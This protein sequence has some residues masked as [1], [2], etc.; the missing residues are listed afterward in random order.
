M[1]SGPMSKSTLPRLFAAAALSGALAACATATPA[2]AA[3][4]ADRPSGAVRRRRLGLR[5]LS[6]RRG[7]AG[8]RR[9]GALRRSICSRPPAA[10]PTLWSSRR[11][12]SPPPSWPAMWTRR[13]PCRRRPAGPTIRATPWA[14]SPVRSWKWLIITTR[15]PTRS[16]RRPWAST[17]RRRRCCG[18]WAAAGAGDRAAS[19]AP[20]AS[21]Q[22]RAVEAFGPAEPR[23]CCWSGAGKVRRGGGGL[24]RP[25]RPQRHLHPWRMEPSWSAGADASRPR[26]STTR[27]WRRI[28]PTQPSPRPGRASPPAVRPP[29]LPSIRTGAAEALVDPAA[30]AAGPEAV[31]CGPRL[32]AA[33]AG[34]RPRPV[35]GVGAGRR[36]ALQADHQGG[37]RACGLR[38]RQADLPGIYH[39]PRPPRAQLGGGRR[40]GPGAGGGSERWRPQSR[41]IPTPCWCWPDIYRDDG[42]YGDAVKDA[43]SADRQGRARHGLQL[44]ALLPPWRSAGARRQV[45]PGP[46]RPTARGER[47]SRRSGSAELSRLRLGGPG[48]EHLDQALRLLQKA[49]ALSPG[50][51]AFVDSLGWAHYRLGPVSGGRCMS[52]STR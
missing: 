2:S 18:P 15:R 42:R 21:G 19:I 12:P 6:R 34:A 13:R 17:G 27:R 37:A 10:I 5:A 26:L 33:G 20:M 47:P 11:A 39:R 46:A 28:P 36:P 48:R 44:A 35:G 52:W 43:G 25:V 31:G 29:P 38:P 23:P 9:A 8:R 7:G 3:R 41:P 30:L 49:N 22:E 32:S 14:S 45:G 40:E 24:R 1:T 16:C 50:S 4:T 51:G